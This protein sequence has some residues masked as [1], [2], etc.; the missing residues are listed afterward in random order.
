MTSPLPEEEKGRRKPVS[1]KIDLKQLVR[2]LLGDAL[3]NQN[4]MPR[5]RKFFERAMIERAVRKWGYS[6]EQ[7]KYALSGWERDIGAAYGDAGHDWSVAG[8]WAIVDD[9]LEDR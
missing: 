3:S 5:N 2:N 8:A 1:E 6:E 7:A 9:F 4:R